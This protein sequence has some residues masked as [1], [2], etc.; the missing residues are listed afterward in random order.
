MLD[1]FL[2][3]PPS[4]ICQCVV[5]CLLPIT[6]ETGHLMETAGCLQ[7][8]GHAGAHSLDG[9]SEFTYRIPATLFGP[10]IL[11][12]QDQP[13]GLFRGTCWRCGAEY[14]M[15]VTGMLA[16]T[17]EAARADTGSVPDDVSHPGPSFYA[18][19]EAR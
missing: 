6:D 3:K 14:A 7:P 8:Q 19:R 17:A 11:L 13:G 4:V 16:D 2:E 18:P 10:R 1:V 5:P 9:S 12:R 15:T